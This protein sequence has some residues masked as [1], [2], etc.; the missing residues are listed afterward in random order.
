M[1]VQIR[2]LKR[3]ARN[4]LGLCRDCDG[5]LHKGGR[6]AERYA[7]HLE[8]RRESRRPAEGATQREDMSQ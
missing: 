5:P 8:R 7:I 6:C 1:N 2:T 4:E 3:K